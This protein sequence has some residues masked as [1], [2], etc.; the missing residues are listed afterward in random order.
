ML[1]GLLEIAL[2]VI[3]LCDQDVCAGLVPG[4]FKFSY[5]EFRLPGKRVGYPEVIVSA[6]AG[7]AEIAMAAGNII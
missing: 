4:A 1:L 2:L 6:L 5:G 7:A 3:N